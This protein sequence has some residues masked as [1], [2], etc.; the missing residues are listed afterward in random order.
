ML[1]VAVAVGAG[2][3]SGSGA[4]WVVWVWVALGVALKTAWGGCLVALVRFRLAF[5]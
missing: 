4:F 5:C 2:F 1:A 3:F